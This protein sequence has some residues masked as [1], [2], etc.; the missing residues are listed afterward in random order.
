MANTLVTGATGRV[1]KHLV[2]ALIKTGQKAIALTRNETVEISG[3]EIFHGDLLDI[4]SLKK[5]VRGVDT[6]FHLAATVDYLATKKTFSAVNVV[7]TRNLLQAS[8]GRKLIYLSSTAAMG[9]KLLEIPASEKTQCNPSD[10]YGQTKLEA[11]LLVRSEGG[12]VIRS[13]DIIGPGFT[14]GYDFVLSRISEGKMVIPGN[15]ENFIQWVHIDDLVQALL[16]AKEKGKPGE[17]YIITGNEKR[18]LNDC[19]RLLAKYLGA[20]PPSNHISKNLAMILI[21]CRLLKAKLSKEKPTALKEYIEKMTANRSFDISKAVNELSFVPG[22]D[23][24]SAVKEM[25]IEYRHSKL[26]INK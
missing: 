20:N 8:N 5:A 2:E 18:T 17:L 21:N 15:G 3:I 11:E 16:L 26:A 24:D 19:L 12:I 23:Y 10:F 6:I 14:E 7:G 9:K 22:V 25:V 1:G 4:G 13:A